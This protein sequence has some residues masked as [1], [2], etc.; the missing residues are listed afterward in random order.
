[1]IGLTSYS[2][3]FSREVP[4]LVS[5]EGVEVHGNQVMRRV[6]SPCAGYAQKAFE[7]LDPPRESLGLLTC[8][9]ATGTTASN[10]DKAWQLAA[11]GRLTGPGFGS[12]RYKRIHP[13]TLVR[14]LQNQVA[15]S[16]S[17]TNDLKGPCLNAPR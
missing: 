10:F 8:S 14:S 15:A 4:D 17:M 1:M 11:D 13:F 7:L 5:M 9:G 6:N 3:V 2:A 12:S 16:L